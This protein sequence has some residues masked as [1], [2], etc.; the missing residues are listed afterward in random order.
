PQFLAR[1]DDDISAAIAGILQEQVV[2]LELN[3]ALQR[4]TSGRDSVSLHTAQGDREVD[5]L[6]VATGSRPATK[7]LKLENAGVVTDAR[8]AVRVDK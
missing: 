8:G 7:A 2:K 3:T 1:E 5:V 4:V 6:L